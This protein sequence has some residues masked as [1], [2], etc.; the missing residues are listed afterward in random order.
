MHYLTR[1]MKSCLQGLRQLAY[2]GLPPNKESLKEE[3]RNAQ[4]AQFRKG[5]A[6]E[7]QIQRSDLNVALKLNVLRHPS[8]VTSS[9]LLIVVRIER[10]SIVAVKVRSVVLD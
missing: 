7:L 2:I 8:K 4:E 3:S 10:P 9:L 5:C 1:T 6:T